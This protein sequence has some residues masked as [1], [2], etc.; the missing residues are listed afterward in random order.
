M[1]TNNMEC[2]MILAKLEE[3]SARLE[4]M[5]A[6]LSALKEQRNKAAG[7]GTAILAALGLLAWFSIHGVPEWLK[8]ALR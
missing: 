8:H 3:M 7:F 4:R 1:P 5:E 6:D 2:G